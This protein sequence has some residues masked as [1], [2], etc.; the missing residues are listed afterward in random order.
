MKATISGVHI[1]GIA[2]VAPPKVVTTDSYAEF[3]GE[4]KIRRI[5][6]STGVE[7]VHVVEPG[8]T[9]SDLCCEAAEKLMQKLGVDKSSIDALVFVSISPDYRAPGTAGIMQG[10]LGLSE[11][12]IAID[13]TFGCSGYVYG[14]YEAALL[15]KGGCKRV[16]LCAGDTQSTLVNEKDRSMK[17]LVGDAGSATIVEEGSDTMQFYF[18]TVG[19]GYES[20]I[21]PAGGCRMPSS[22]ETSIEIEDEDGNI[23]SKEN[24]FMD[25][26]GVMKFALTEVPL[27]MDK[28]YEMTGCSKEDVDLFAYHQPNKLILDYLSNSMEIPAEKMPVG[29]QRVGNT[30]SASIPMLLHTLYDRGFDFKTKE[31]IIACGFGIGLSIGAARLNLKKTEFV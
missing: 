11:E 23:R 21:I 28:M 27:A 19:S 3:F 10:K 7:S 25:G 2:T 4:K 18:K 20:L 14:L 31:K 30:A 8:V 1:A 29:L 9:A 13:L 16:L 15:L 24:L 12:I 5:K 17:M 22:A 26:M 6:R